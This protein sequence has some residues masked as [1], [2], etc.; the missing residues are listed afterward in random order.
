MIKDTR[1]DPKGI[2][3]L[4]NKVNLK[5][6]QKLIIIFLI[7]NVV[8]I[9]LLS[10]VA[11]VHI[12]TLSGSLR[13]T[14]VID[15]MNALNDSSRDKLERITVEIAKSVT[16]FLHRRDQDILTLSALPHSEDIY[17]NFS[18]NKNSRIVIA[19]EWEVSKDGMH[20]VEKNPFGFAGA[21]NKS[22]NVENNDVLYGSGFNNRPPEFFEDYKEY[23]PLYDEIT[24]IDLQGNEIYK[25]VNKNTT[26]IHYPMNPSKQNVSDRQNT[27]VRS[28]NYFHQLQKLAKGQIYVSD[29]IGAYVGT[30][31]I[32]M[33]TPGVLKNIP[34]SHPN[35][36]ELQRIA[37]LSMDDFLE[38][39]KKQAYA[40]LENPIGQRFE[41]IIRWGT[42]VYRNN[43]KIGYVT[44]A[45]DHIHIMEFVDYID[46][47][48][49]RYT[50]LPSPNNGNYAFIWDY[51]CRSICHPRHHSIVGYNPLTGEIQVPWLEGTIALE[52]DFIKGGFKRNE[53]NQTIPILVNGETTLANDTPFY[54]WITNGGDKWLDD[55]PSWDFFNLSK[56]VTGKNWW[57]IKPPNE[58][59][60]YTS[61]GSFYKD[62]VD[63]REILPQ[64]GERILTK[65]DGSIATDE[66]GN[67]L[68][69]YQSRSKAPARA[70]TKGG[71]VGLDGRY[72]NNAPQCTGWMDLT[73]NGGSGS[74]YI[75]WSGLYKPTT[76]G[77][78]QYYTGKYHPNERH[79]SKRGFAFV[80]I[81]AG[82]DDFTE[83]AR[84]ME[85]RLNKTISKTLFTSMI[86]LIVIVGV[87]LLVIVFIALS[88]STYITGNINILLDGFT[89]FRSGLR[90]FRLKSDIKDE[91][92]ILAKSF[93][94]M[95][96]S[97]ESSV[98][99]MLVI[100]DLDFNIIYANETTKQVFN[101]PLEDIY[102]KPYINVSIYPSKSRFD[103]I[104]ALHES[105]ESDVMFVQE[106]NRYYKGIA[107]YLLDRHEKQIGYIVTT[108]DVSEIEIA[109]LKAEQAS[110]TKSTFLANMSHEIRTPMN[111]IMGITEILM[112]TEGLS[113]NF[114]E[115]LERIHI[116]CELLLGIINDILDLSKIEA[117]KM[118]LIL[119]EY[120]LASLINDTTQLNMLRINGKPIIFELEIDENL[121]AKLLGDELRIKQI[122]NNVLSNAFKYTDEGK[123]LFSITFEGLAGSNEVTLIIKIKDTGHG[124]TK[125]NVDNIFDA[126]SRFIDKNRKAV[127][128]TGLGL[129]ITNQLIKLMNGTIIVESEVNIGTLV[130]IRLP[131]QIVGSDVFTSEIVESLK[132]FRS[133]RNIS[134]IR[135][136]IS[137]VPMPY[138]KILIVDDVE[139]NLYVA[140][141][142]MTQYKLR[143][144][145]VMSGQEAIDNINDG[146]EYDLIFMDHMMPVLD[147][148]ETTKILRD[149]GYTKPI[150][151]LTANAVHGQSEMF[152]NNG[153]DDFISKPIDVN[154]LDTI[155]KKYVRDRN[156]NKDISLEQ[157]QDVTEED[158]IDSDNNQIDNFLVD[159]FLRETNKAINT[160][161]AIENYEEDSILKNYIIVVHGAKSSL[162]NM[163][164]NELAEIAYNLEVAGRE[165]NFE[166]IKSI[167]P[168][169]INSL[170]NLLDKYK[171]NNEE[172][173]ETEDTEVLVSKLSSI[174]ELCSDYDRKGVLD[175]INGIDKMTKNTFEILDRLKVI[176]N[177]SEFE[178]A[179]QIVA[180]YLTEIE[181]KPR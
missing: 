73:G 165:K 5:L 111:A 145:T 164:E 139:T 66:K 39:A 141:G 148:I 4:L 95:A 77:A 20:W 3:K 128:G 46:P 14:A 90:Q 160:L 117:G 26:K 71:Y 151:V 140:R 55:Y 162:Y 99:D 176:I 156:Q 174:K 155:L 137:R 68:L 83:P 158:I 80:T 127:E 13:D 51:N 114:E 143:I 118:N 72:L 6:H 129:A 15:S 149:N 81:G 86:Q 30:N 87:L 154:Q 113:R 84:I 40:G 85:Q 44:M 63:N 150:V 17:S 21:T 169:F 2:A 23:R 173:A 36:D 29:V 161:K 10:V 92:G 123:V 110:I 38:V 97:I 82:I 125:E 49:E 8:P 108:H 16:E 25:Y 45:L 22:N 27:Y 153:F 138:G 70:L 96:D 179:E 166:Y 28:E 52:R 35:Y 19:K 11:F 157:Y 76:A 69:D 59:S 107:I 88:I 101:K 67:I 172:F 50:L 64:F 43:I 62:N 168:A 167:T 33:Y 100:I 24:F 12:F 47:M 136:K 32:G 34:K 61:W 94:E 119:S 37:N 133:T 171:K 56:V 75:L 74:F 93:D 31:Y 112:G 18:N 122:L 60:L 120:Y 132:K 181:N 104:L 1:K 121:P 175:L 79:G 142:L 58:T 91:F 78:I 103:P 152:L 115:S 54:F 131:Q 144:D 170:L 134:E 7:V 130:T 89:R 106:T 48:H 102:G 146:I 126:Y 159:S 116:S 42:P 9:I 105:R 163:K 135:A 109:R 180:E 65:P 53:E 147:G 98:N 41:G 57:E 124:M 178:E 177:N